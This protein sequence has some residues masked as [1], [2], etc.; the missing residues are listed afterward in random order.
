MGIIE[1]I[2]NDGAEQL[3]IAYLLNNAI[4]SYAI[5]RII[6]I[7][8]TLLDINVKTLNQTELDDLMLLY[9]AG[10]AQLLLDAK[11]I[12]EFNEYK[13]INSDEI[14]QYSETIR[15]QYI[16][17]GTGQAIVYQD[18]RDEANSYIAA[19]YPVDLSGSTWAESG[20][21]YPPGARPGPF[22]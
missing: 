20:F 6:S 14:D 10:T 13:I 2:T 7:D 17:F 21:L 12:D 9:D 19:G 4:E 18:K 15:L 22:L 1:N 3:I 5:E 16:T 8:K 11:I